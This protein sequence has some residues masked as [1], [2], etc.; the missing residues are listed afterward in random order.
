[1]KTKYHALH[2]IKLARQLKEI[3]LTAE[4][5]ALMEELKNASVHGEFAACFPFVLNL[6]PVLFEQ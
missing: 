4:D 1:M 5:L 2:L 3:E 6:L